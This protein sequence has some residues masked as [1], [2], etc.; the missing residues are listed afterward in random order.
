MLNGIFRKYIPTTKYQIKGNPCTPKRGKNR[1][2]IIILSNLNVFDSGENK[3]VVETPHRGDEVADEVLVRG[4]HDFV[5][6]NNIINPRLQVEQGDMGG[7]PM[8][9][10]GVDREDGDVIVFDGHGDKDAS[11]GKG[12]EDVRVNVEDLGTV[13]DGLG[14]EEV[15]QR[16]LIF[17]H[18]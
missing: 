7:D 5:A 17:S 3:S 12:Q 18:F 9:R 4:G 10:V 14:L 11:V 13:D 16:E 8:V 15:G 6:N 2:K 1:A